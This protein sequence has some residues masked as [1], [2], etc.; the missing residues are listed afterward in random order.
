MLYTRMDSPVGELLIVSDGRCLTGLYIQCQP[1][2]SWQQGDLTLFDTVKSWLT[3]YFAGKRPDVSDLP[4]KLTGTPFQ[5]AVWAYLLTIPY[6]QTCTYGDIARKMAA[7]AGKKTMSAQAVGQAVGRNPISIIVPC[8]RVVGAGG[9][10]T[11]YA[12][13][14]EKK[15]WLL[16]HEAGTREEN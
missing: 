7:L 9:K 13:G 3:G 8:H 16:A 2:P 14:I 4:L 10:M 11:G 5:K 1:E 15:E 12:W 6:G